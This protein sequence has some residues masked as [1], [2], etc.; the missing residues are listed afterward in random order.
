ALYGMLVTTL[1]EHSDEVG[2]I[3]FSPDGKTIATASS[4]GTAKLWNKDGTLLDWAEF[5]PCYEMK[6][7]LRD[8]PSVQ[9]EDRNLCD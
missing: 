1:A 8:S 3:R 5:H 7:Y 9:A 4:D 6:S 2:A